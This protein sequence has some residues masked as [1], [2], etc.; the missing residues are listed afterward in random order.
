MSKAL[1]LIAPGFE[2]IEFCVPVDILRRGDV[3]VTIAS[4]LGQSSYSINHCLHSENHRISKF[5]DIMLSL[6]LPVGNKQSFI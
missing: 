5:R 4:I 3:E 6:N 2:E 1:V